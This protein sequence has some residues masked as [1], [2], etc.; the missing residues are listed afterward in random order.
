MQFFK[1][2]DFRVCNIQRITEKGVLGLPASEGLA[3][4]Y[5]DT[6][7]D[8][9]DLKSTYLVIAFVYY[10][11]GEECYYYESVLNRIEKA[12][13]CEDNLNNFTLCLTACQKLFR[14][15]FNSLEEDLDKKD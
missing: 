11:K 14:E 9:E 13:Q 4:E 5:K 10:D 1:A 12:I 15:Y 2:G 8:G 6:F 7:K 3:I